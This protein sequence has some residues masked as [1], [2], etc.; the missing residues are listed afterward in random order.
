MFNSIITGSITITSL[1]ICLST[2]TKFAKININYRILKIT[3]MESLYTFNYSIV[4]KN[5]I[6]KKEFIDDSQIR[7]KNLR[8]IMKHPSYESGL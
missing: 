5:N 1:L 2:L 4:I 6:N 7:N 3:N 8:I